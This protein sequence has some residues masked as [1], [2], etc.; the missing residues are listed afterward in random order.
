MILFMTYINLITTS[1]DSQ[2]LVGHIAK[3]ARN[4]YNS[5]NEFSEY[6]TVESLSHTTGEIPDA[7]VNLR[8]VI[9]RL[10]NAANANLDTLESLSTQMNQNMEWVKESH[11]VVL[12]CEREMDRLKANDTD[13]ARGLEAVQE[14][15]RS[16]IKPGL[17]DL[18]ARGSSDSQ[19]YM[20]MTANQS[21]QDLTGQTLKKVIAFIETLQFKLLQLLPNYD[22]GEEKTAMATGD[23]GDSS[24][25]KAAADPIQSQEKVDQ[26]LAD[27]GF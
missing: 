27:L 22:A 26:L 3:I 7:V 11:G 24:Q 15:L 4:I 25:E 10:E 18:E 1:S 6:L 8:T 23:A 21:F 14:I 17:T 12:E 2:D 5:L 16:E 20:A 19:T 13:L 9:T